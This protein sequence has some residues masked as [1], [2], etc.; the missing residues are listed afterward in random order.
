MTLWLIILGMVVVTYTVRLSVI[1]LLGSAEMPDTMNR[2]LRFVPPAALSA[3][4]FPE[5]LMPE[6]IFDP[7]PGNVRLVA[8]LVAA[9]VAWRA[10]NTL[11]A[12][13]VGMVVL[14]TLQTVV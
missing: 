9:V 7:S 11:L 8:G 14:W 13:G 3:I 5:L 6:G 12:I 1:A 10:K 2:A 4:V